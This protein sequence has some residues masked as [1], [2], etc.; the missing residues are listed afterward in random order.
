MCPNTFLCEQSIF[1]NSLLYLL[2]AFSYFI[3]EVSRSKAD[4]MVAA[5]IRRKEGMIERRQEGRIK[6]RRQKERRDE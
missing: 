2:C 4:E 5:E 1:K 6:G 3:I